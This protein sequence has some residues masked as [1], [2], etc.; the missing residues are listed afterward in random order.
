MCVCVWVWNVQG[1]KMW[2]WW[3]KTGVVSTG[4]VAPTH[5]IHVSLTAFSCKFVYSFFL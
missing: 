3:K 5:D 2:S 1:K 4:K